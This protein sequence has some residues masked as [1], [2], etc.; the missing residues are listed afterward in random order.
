[1]KVLPNNAENQMNIMQTSYI[2]KNINN[3]LKIKCDTCTKLKSYNEWL[4][5]Q[6]NVEEKSE[7]K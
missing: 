4:W 7:I 1:M 3:F 6:Y 2:W 5:F